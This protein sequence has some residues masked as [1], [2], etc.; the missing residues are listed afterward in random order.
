MRILIR[1]KSNMIAPLNLFMLL[2]VSRMLIVFTVSSAVLKSTYSADILI[3]IMCALL[4]V[5]LASVPVM[6]LIKNGKNVL[7]S[8][9]VSAAYGL[10]FIYAGAINVGKFAMFSATELNQN[11][12]LFFLAVSMAAA[13]IYAS[14][15][16]I[17][18]ISRFG[19][20]VFVLMII[21]FAGL[22]CFCVKDFSALNIFPLVQN[23][24][25]EIFM[26]ALLSAASTNELLL[27]F[28]LAP[29]I[30]GKIKKPFYFSILLSFL[31]SML[32]ILLVIGVLGDTASFYSYP[33]FELSQTAKL[34]TN[35]RLETIFIALWIFAVFLKITLYL[36]CAASCFKMK[37]GNKGRLKCLICGAAMFLASWLIISTG[38]YERAGNYSDIILF[39][40]FAVAIPVLYLIFGK[41]K[42][43]SDSLEAFENI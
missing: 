36:Y 7:N 42:R 27:V 1:Y 13:C 10:Y 12:K 14:S 17:E 9:I 25:K 39:F 30:N 16:G 15:L 4:I 40:V 41:R 5:L 38:A 18:A 3:S 26:N 2:A 11:T 31:L 33:V 37:K 6:K 29:K 20:F 24:G 23:G 35:G 22:I 21:G 28:V 34:G 19:S 32:M 8:R 43:S